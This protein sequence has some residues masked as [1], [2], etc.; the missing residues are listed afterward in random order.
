MSEQFEQVSKWIYAGVW[1]M[2]TRWFRVPDHPPA[3]PSA[4]GTSIESFKPAIGFLNYLQLQFW[5]GLIVIDHAILIIEIIIIINEPTVGLVLLIPAIFVAV[6][7]DVIVYLAIHLRYDTTWY[8]LS[9]RSVRIRRGIWIIHET[10][11]TFENIQNVSVRQGPLQRWFGIA[12]VSI[13]TAG[14]G[15]QQAHGQGNPWQ[16]SHCGL[17][18]GVAD[19]H[20]IRDLIMSRLKLSSSAGLGDEKPTAPNTGWTAEQVATLREIRDLIAAS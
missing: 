18:E 2:M 6:V 9:D 4:P 7:P 10:T 20:R 1:G 15:G 3:L 12:D 16:A 13:E 5:V 17:I 11:I 19:A 14:G 8:V